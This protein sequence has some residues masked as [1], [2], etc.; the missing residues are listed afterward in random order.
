[1]RRR[2]K[3]EL[4]D[5]LVRAVMNHREPLARAAI[6]LDVPVST[7]S[8][9]VRR[10]QAEAERTRDGVRAPA[11]RRPMFIELMPASARDARLVVR[12]GVAEVEVRTGFDAALLRE[13]VEA[14][15]GGQP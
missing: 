9:W 8:R 5:E 15:R 4:K 11:T 3:Q 13:V 10:P 2:Y 12:V 1:M 7:A 14:L 6:R